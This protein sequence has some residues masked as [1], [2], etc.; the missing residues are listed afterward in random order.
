[1]QG[2]T[3]IKATRMNKKIRNPKNNKVTLEPMPLVVVEVP[4]DQSNIYN[5]TPVLE[6]RV[7]PESLRRPSISQCHRCQQ[8]GH[9]QNCCY[10]PPM[11]VK[12]GQGH[13]SATCANNNKPAF[14]GNCRTQ[15]HTANW[16]GCPR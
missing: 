16:S 10:A 5:I 15:G 14:C 8:F 7:V 2:F 3:V 11:C 12:C 1:M 13:L 4:R 6:T 9:A